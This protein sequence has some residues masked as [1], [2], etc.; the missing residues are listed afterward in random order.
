MALV[1][2]TVVG[3][4]ADS[5]STILYHDSPNEQDISNVAR[6]STLWATTELPIDNS[7]KGDRGADV[8]IREPTENGMIFRALEIPPDM[9]DKAEHIK[10]MKDLNQ[11]VKQKYTPT[12]RDL[13]RDPTMHRTDTLDC[14]VLVRGEIYLV[15]D[16]DEVL[17]EPGDTY[18]I[19][20]VNHAWS[21]RSNTPALIVATMM[22]SNPVTFTP[23]EIAYLNSQRVGRLATVGPDG[24]PHNVP[25]GFHYNAALGTIDI[26]G[27]GLARSRKFRDI[28]CDQHVAFVVD[29]LAPVHGETDVDRP[30][31]TVH[32]ETVHGIE[33]RGTAEALNYG[34]ATLGP[35]F[36][37]DLIRVYP[38]RI[39]AWNLDE[40]GQRARD[41]TA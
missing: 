26:G 7:I 11:T 8:T 20:G 16:T 32:G 1:K 40:G 24:A 6:R 25:V 10:L 15:T 2:R 30:P 37:Q 41:V 13:A 23:N 35:G 12:D 18:V 3:A 21:N 28:G 29:D 22:H 9:P 36:D 27:H 19:E 31:W 33:I 17:L 38:R 14:G 34:G 5:Q 4:N 39:I